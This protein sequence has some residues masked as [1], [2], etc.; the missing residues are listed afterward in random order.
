MRGNL[1]RDLSRGSMDATLCIVNVFQISR[2]AASCLHWQ[3]GLS[4]QRSK[5]VKRCEI[6]E[7]VRGS[8]NTQLNG[9]G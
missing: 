8:S 4:F 5:R 7:S 9:Y 6:R 3:D 1:V 2:K